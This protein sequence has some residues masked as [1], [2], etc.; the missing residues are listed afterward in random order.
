MPGWDARHNEWGT[1]EGLN[2]LNKL[3]ELN[4]LT[5]PA[6]RSLLHPPS[7]S[8]WRTKEE[9]ERSHRSQWLKD[10]QRARRRR[11]PSP[12]L[13]ERGWGR[14]GPYRVSSFRKSRHQVGG[15]A[16]PQRRD[17]HSAAEPQPSRSAP[18]PGR[19]KV[20]R[21]TGSKTS[22]TI[23][24]RTLRLLPSLRRSRLCGLIGFAS[25]AQPAKQLR[26]SCTRLVLHH[27][28]LTALATS[29]A[30]NTTNCAP[31]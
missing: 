16:K 7:S 12:P 5:A 20:H 6:S 3:N 11:L 8:L 15:S 18:V 19:S 28:T 23:P 9:R 30:L 31:E 10:I 24:L 21:P 4:E 26:H 27:S 29:S 13:E 22:A 25:F 17:R 1:V 2:K 14:G